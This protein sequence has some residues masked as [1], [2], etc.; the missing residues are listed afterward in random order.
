MSAYRS[1][2]LIASAHVDFS[3]KNDARTITIDFRDDSA[4]K[5]ILQQLHSPDFL[6]R[7]NLSLHFENLKGNDVLPVIDVYLNLENEFLPE[8]TNYVG[9]M[10]L[11]GIVESSTASAEHDGSGQHRIFNAGQ[12]FVNAYNQSNWSE[13]QFK[14][15]LIPSDGFVE[16]ALVIGRVVVRCNL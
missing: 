1:S 13:K 14:L 7:F 12:A 4:T 5:A 11:Y 15:T 3:L 9:S 10:A 8:E 16:D 6:S 2:Q